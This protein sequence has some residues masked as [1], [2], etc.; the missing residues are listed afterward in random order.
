MIT[1]LRVLPQPI[2][3]KNADSMARVE[4][5]YDEFASSVLGLASYML[6]DTKL[7]KAVTVEVFVAAQRDG[8]SWTRDQCLDRLLE[9][10]RTRAVRQ[11]RMRG[12]RRP[13]RRFRRTTWP[14]NEVQPL[15]RGV[16]HAAYFEG[17]TLDELMIHIPLIGAQI[18]RVI[19]IF[20]FLLSFVDDSTG[21]NSAMV[22]V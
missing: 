3:S 5:W 15:H 6:D 1:R 13:M 9:L 21:I 22:K 20:E 8:A 2:E 14:Q 12:H 17:D 16:I 4:A 11:I 10:T 19:L 18:K 7:A